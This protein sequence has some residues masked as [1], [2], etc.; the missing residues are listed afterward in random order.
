MQPQS[1]VERAKLKARSDAP[2]PSGEDRGWWVVE[3]KEGD[4]PLHVACSQPG[5]ADAIKLAVETYG[6]DVDQPSSLN[7]ATPLHVAAG[8]PA[9]DL[10]VI[11]YLLRKGADPL[12][13]TSMDMTPLHF[14]CGHAGSTEAVAVLLRKGASPVATTSRGL[15]PLHLAASLPTDGTLQLLLPVTPDIDA[16]DHAGMTP[17]HHACQV[18]GAM[19]C[20]TL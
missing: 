16:T 7:A 9:V 5:T 2:L 20:S 3:D 11:E 4:T 1:A 6:A 15:V 17:L 14:A 18:C 8:A 13:R 19:Q 12:L 10:S